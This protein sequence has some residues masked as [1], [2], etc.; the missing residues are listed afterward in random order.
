M[1]TE[2][3][4]MVR[5]VVGATLL[6]CVV[7]LVAWMGHEMVASRDVEPERVS[8]RA[9]DRFGGVVRRGPTRRTAYTSGILGTVSDLGDNPVGSGIDV[10]L[11]EVSRGG[12]VQ[13]VRTAQTDE[14]GRFRFEELGP[15]SYRVSAS[16]GGWITR[17]GGASVTIGGA[18]F[19]HVS[20]VVAHGG[21]EVH[22]TVT[23]RDGRGLEGAAVAWVGRSGGAD[24]ATA[25]T[26]TTDGEGRYSIVVPPTVGNITASADGFADASQLDDGRAAAIDLALWPAASIIGQVVDARGAAV[27]EAVVYAGAPAHDGRHIGRGEAVAFTN[28]S[29]Q[30]ELDALRPGLTDLHAVGPAG[31]SRAL[32]VTAPA[33][34]SIGPLRLVLDD[35]ATVRGRVV[36]SDGRGLPGFEVV[37]QM[38]AGSASAVGGTDGDG[39]FVIHGIVGEECQ[40]VAGN[41]QIALAA[42]ATVTIDR[43]SIEGVE[44]RAAL[45]GRL[46]G[47]VAPPVAARIELVQAGGSGVAMQ[48]IYSDGEGRFAFAHTPEGAFEV[49][50]IADDGRVGRLASTGPGEDVVVE[51]VDGWTVP[52]HVEYH[53]GAAIEGLSVVARGALGTTTVPV[54]TDGSFTLRGSDDGVVH[55]GLLAAGQPIRIVEGE[56]EGERVAVVEFD[57]GQDESIELVAE[58]LEGRIDGIVRGRGGQPIAAAR[59]VAV[60]DRIPVAER[61]GLEPATTTC[62]ASL[63]PQSS[64]AVAT[65]TD[66]DGAFSVSGLR[67]DLVY[68]V[69]VESTDRSGR[70]CVGRVVPGAQVSVE[71]ERG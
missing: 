26:G 31:V 53:S 21:R 62:M 60:P 46:T 42:I 43:R 33:G 71:I 68:A 16:G 52:G 19:H 38:E 4:S 47:R 7:G 17:N 5:V 27:A 24:P 56:G 15:G 58:A 34:G 57:P 29:G 20:V 66:R 30:F 55:V 32:T 65:V 49:R 6:A 11:S 51:L 1:T 8:S 23:D 44:L 18:D 50:A 35:A 45:A 13:P 2:W 36:A 41:E 40:L 54:A 69:M 3:R 12:A 64:D 9:G 59:V 28:G 48:P 63:S 61:M 37:C 67:S 39:M 10:T 22:G 14:H 25:F 70:G